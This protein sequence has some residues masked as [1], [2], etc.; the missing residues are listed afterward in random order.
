ML[1]TK[2]RAITDSIDHFDCTAVFIREDQV[3]IPLVINKVTNTM[4]MTLYNLLALTCVAEGRQILLCTPR[5]GTESG[6]FCVQTAKIYRRNYS[7]HNTSTIK[8]I[9]IIC[10]SL[11]CLIQKSTL[12]SLM[13]SHEREV[14]RQ[15]R[16]HLKSNNIQDVHNKLSCFL[17][18]MCKQGLTPIVE[19]RYIHYS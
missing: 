16:Y 19:G 6:L 17:E 13:D 11:F 10:N 4:H 18:W 8:F 1:Q 15:F 14:G 5:Y 12:Y 2:E 9:D 7:M 3:S